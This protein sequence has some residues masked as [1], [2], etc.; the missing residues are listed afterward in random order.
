MRLYC[1]NGGSSTNS[2]SNYELG[3]ETGVSIMKI[4]PRLDAGPV[5]L[6]EKIKISKEITYQDLSKKCPK[7]EQN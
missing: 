2:K 5:M 6:K 7:S 3:P 4:T 1:L